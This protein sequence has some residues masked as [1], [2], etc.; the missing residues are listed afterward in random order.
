LA[1]VSFDLE[2][3]KQSPFVITVVGPTNVGKTTLIRT[4]AED[5][6][7]GQVRNEPTVTKV[8]APTNVSIGGHEI[9][10]LID[11]PGFECAEDIIKKFGKRPT[12]DEVR[13]FVNE[14]GDSPLASALQAIEQA[15][16]LL[17]VVDVRQQQAEGDDDLFSVLRPLAKPIVPILNF[18]TAPINHRQLWEER[19]ATAGLHAILPF[20]AHVR[21][22]DDDR[23]LFQKIRALLPNASPHAPFVDWWTQRRQDAF[24]RRQR[25]VAKI[26][27]DWTIRVIKLQKEKSNVDPEQVDTASQEL[28]S[29]LG[30]GLNWETMAAIGLMKKAY[31][32]PDSVALDL[33]LNEVS[34]EEK[35]ENHL[36]GPSV[37]KQVMAGA[38][39]GL[40]IGTAVDVLTLGATLGMGTL[41]GGGIGSLV[42]CATATAINFQFDAKNRVLTASFS[43][44]KI[45]SRLA[46][47][48]GVARY[49]H[50]LGMAAFGNQDNAPANRSIKIPLD[51]PYESKIRPELE[52]MLKRLRDPRRNAFSR[53]QTSFSG[54]GGVR[55]A[56][57]ELLRLM[58]ESKI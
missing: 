14:S 13:R 26:L 36:L 22:A 31:D 11:T 10:R 53:I 3:L 2:A 48:L 27:A 6:T 28:L 44:S 29:E 33:R 25:S 49:L 4:I 45:A 56:D 19:L 58:L 5:C 52:D 38:A 7:F 20:D 57:E 47:F 30:N 8:A 21:T 9:V 15:H 17:Y 12:A 51:E 43:T 54:N 39:I 16:V 34:G 37:G 50:R 18:L 32:I 55:Q 40:L 46:Q 41:L 35:D 24:D 23:N 42:G 1:E